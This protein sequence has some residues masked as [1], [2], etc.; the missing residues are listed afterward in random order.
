[1][2][3]MVLGLKIDAQDG[4]HHFLQAVWRLWKDRLK[5]ETHRNPCLRG[6]NYEHL[7]TGH[8]RIHMEPL[9]EVCR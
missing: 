5:E 4:P 2:G 3:L 8:T 7:F 1:M 9:Y 6:V